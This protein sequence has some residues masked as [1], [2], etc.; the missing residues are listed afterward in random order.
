MSRVTIH[1]GAHNHLVVDGKC[2]ELIEETKRLIA[3]EVDRMLDAKI[4][5]ISF[6][7]SKTLASYLFDDSGNGIVEF[8]KGE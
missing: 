8:F 2:C 3:E 1:L 5:S 7:A 6:N 4:F